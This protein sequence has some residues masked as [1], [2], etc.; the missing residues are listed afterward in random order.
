MRTAWVFLLVSIAPAV[1]AADTVS[2][3][4]CEMRLE[5]TLAVMQDRSLLKEEHAT[6]LMWLR[7]DAQTAIT[8]GD[9]QECLANVVI[10]E[11]LLG[12]ETPEKSATSD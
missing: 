8:Q 3:S 4:G 10:T 2:L 6:A 7:M 9:E 12:I 5:Q 1:M 11:R